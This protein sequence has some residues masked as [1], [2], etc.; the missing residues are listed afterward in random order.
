MP[1]ACY[2]LVAM[3]VSYAEALAT[4]EALMPLSTLFLPAAAARQL[5]VEQY[6]RNAGPLPSYW[7]GISRPDSSNISLPDE[8][9]QPYRMQDGGYVPPSVSIGDS[10]PYG[11]WAWP[12]AAAAGVP[13]ADCVLAEMQLAFDRWAAGATGRS[14]CKHARL[15]TMAR[16]SGAHGDPFPAAAGVH[17]LHCCGKMRRR[18]AAVWSMPGCPPASRR[19]RA[20]LRRRY[21]GASSD[22]L[23]AGNASHYEAPSRRYPDSKYGWVPRPCDLEAALICAA[24]PEQ[25]PCQ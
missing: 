6:F 17:A 23:D 4:C 13:G 19:L 25:L 21:L 8:L 12:A 24:L 15:L 3:P 9:F 16:D 7:T 18:C 10:E 5:Q 2:R 20:R 22:A 1:E 14:S 11:H